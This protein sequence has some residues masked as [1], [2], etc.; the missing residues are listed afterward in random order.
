[1]KTQT[2]N[3]IATCVKLA[4]ERFGEFVETETQEVFL[5]IKEAKSRG[6]LQKQPPDRCLNPYI[7]AANR[8]LETF[9]TETFFPTLSKDLTH[10]YAYVALVATNTIR[11]TAA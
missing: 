2:E 6:L 3:H 11:I 9:G 10:I 8:I 5:I 4:K 7:N 1:M